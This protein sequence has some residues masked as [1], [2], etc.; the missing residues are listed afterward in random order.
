MKVFRVERERYLK[1]TL[2][3]LG[4]SRSEGCR[5]N[6]L[7]TRMVYTAETRALATLEVAVHLDMHEDLPTDRFYVE[8]DIPDDLPILEV[9]PADLPLQWDSKPPTVLTQVIGDDFVLYQEAAVLK[10]PS[11][12]I[13]Q[14]SNYLINPA[15]SDAARIKVTSTSRMQFD[16]R[17]RGIKEAG[18]KK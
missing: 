2:Q 4:A 14:E 6:S 18:R 13:S 11:S 16:G 3:G 1:A 5:W 8:I 9:R 7:Y 17:I 12:I 10:V 15:H